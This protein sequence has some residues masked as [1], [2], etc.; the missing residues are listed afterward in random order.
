M[1]YEAAMR[2]DDLMKTWVQNT[3]VDFMDNSGDLEYHIKKIERHGWNALWKTFMWVAILLGVIM[4]LPGKGFDT[5][6]CYAATALFTVLYIMIYCMTMKWDVRKAVKQFNK[7]WRLLEAGGIDRNKASIEHDLR[8]M[9]EQ[10]DEMKRRGDPSANKHRKEFGFLHGAM[11]R[12]GLAERTWHPYFPKKERDLHD[13]DN[14][15]RD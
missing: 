14:H 15:R 4:L 5:E 12:F 8:I 1:G 6:S 11:F 13:Q 9:G 2:R 10:Q 3:K 7:D